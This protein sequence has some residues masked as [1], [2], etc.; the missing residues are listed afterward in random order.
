MQ[1]NFSQQMRMSQQMKLAP[2]MIQSMEILQLPVMALEERIEQEISENP[3]LEKLQSD[4]DAP[5]A[6][7][8]REEARE[9][10]AEK[11]L[12]EQVLQVDSDHNN[13]ADFERLLEISQD[14]P[15]D[16]YTSGSKPSSSR[17]E[18]FVT[19]ARRFS[20]FPATRPA[21]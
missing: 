7:H 15:E 1:L 2:R 17:M 20:A 19:S 4:P 9:E 11:S 16:N 21:N 12:G 8:N 10:A 5:E 14:W 13:E 3:C 6:E 18:S